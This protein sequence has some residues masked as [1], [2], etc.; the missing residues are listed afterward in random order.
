MFCM[1]WISLFAWK[2]SI[3]NGFIFASICLA[4][5][6]KENA[7]T[8]V[9]IKPWQATFVFLAAF[10]SMAQKL[11]GSKS[12]LS[13]DW[14]KKNNE[15]TVLSWSFILTKA[16]LVLFLERE[17]IRL[18]GL[19]S[20]LTFTEAQS[21]YMKL[22]VIH[23]QLN[24]KCTFRGH[25]KSL[26]LVPLPCV[27]IKTRAIPYRGSQ[28]FEDHWLGGCVGL[29]AVPV[30]LKSNSELRVW[31]GQWQTESTVDWFGPEEGERW[32]INLLS[33][34]SDLRWC[35][36]GKMRA[37]L[38]CC[39]KLHWLYISVDKM[40][41]SGLNSNVC[42]LE[43]DKTCKK[44][45]CYSAVQIQWWLSV[46]VCQYIFVQ[47]QY[48]L[49]LPIDIGRQYVLKEIIH[50]GW[51]IMKYSNFVATVSLKLTVNINSL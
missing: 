6:L 38:V 22:F 21:L 16:T 46:Y 44:C 12:F 24:D 4:W 47:L 39:F 14:Q 42:D 31:L 9:T 17:A 41:N 23:Y 28:P 10:L 27:S 35:G 32:Q 30:P 19:M 20:N 11:P 48:M 3:E 43:H 7:G 49:C 50:S 2:W 13:F 29:W 26:D 25:I 37:K 33:L 51:C 5:K 1:N 45:W 8:V 40:N 15:E 36:E 18:E 34:H